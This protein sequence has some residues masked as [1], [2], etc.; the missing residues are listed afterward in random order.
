M[1][2]LAFYIKPK[3]S[4]TY[5]VGDDESGTLTLTKLGCLTVKEELGLR[6]IM[7]N[8]DLNSTPFFDFQLA[9]ATLAIQLR[10][11]ESWQQSDT[12]GLTVPL[13]EKTYEFF[14]EKERSRWENKSYSLKFEGKKAKE[15]AVNFAEKAND[16][17][18]I[19]PND[20]E[21]SKIY[22]IYDSESDVPDGYEL[23]SGKKSIESSTETVKPTGIS[24]T[25]N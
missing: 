2:E 24:S 21:D 3:K 5:T 16:I 11:S 1:T 10:G 13:V 15:L 23:L 7:K 25:G 12:E 4:T 18:A 17:I 19:N 20:P 22:Y 9:I 8:I 14:F 6:D